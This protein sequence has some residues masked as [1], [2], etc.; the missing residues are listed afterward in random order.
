MK[1]KHSIGGTNDSRK[2]TKALYFRQVLLN[3]EACFLLAGKQSSDINPRTVVSP[4]W[5]YSGHLTFNLRR[6][7]TP[8]TF[9]NLTLA[10]PTCTQPGMTELSRQHSTSKRLSYVILVFIIFPL[11]PFFHHSFRL[12]PGQATLRRCPRGLPGAG[13]AG[14]AARQEQLGNQLVPPCCT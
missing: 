7:N 2:E 1:L 3:L 12:G 5:C 8:T 6:F 9:V 14:W 10:E 13:Q 4:S 11:P